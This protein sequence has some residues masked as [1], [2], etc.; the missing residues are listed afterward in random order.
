MNCKII[1]EGMIGTQ[2]QCIGIANACNVLYSIEKIGL[3]Q[4]WKTFSPWLGFEKSWSFSPPINPPYPDLLITSG[5]KSIAASRYIKK[6]SDGKTFT[7]YVQNPKISPNNFDLV[8]V[9]FH[10]DYR[11]D[12]VIVTDG[13]PNKITP[14]LLAQAKEEFSPQFKKLTGKKVAVLIG[15]YSKTYHLSKERTLKLTKELLS[16]DANLMVT[17]SRRTG[18]ENFALLSQAFDTDNSFFWNGQTPNPYLGMLAWADH[19]IVTNDSVSMISDAGTTGKPVHLIKLD[20]HS[21]KFDRF[22]DHMKN[23]HITRIFDGTLDEW[24][25]KPLRDA[26]KVAEAVKTRLG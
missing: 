12:N 7:L 10:D 22:D 11:G 13:A 24:N 19:I 18:E 3:N 15:G 25:Y 4:P 20:G 1:T 16:L 23:L 26:Q 2:N 14:E 9:P 8:A 5:R 17:A 6:Q 21:K